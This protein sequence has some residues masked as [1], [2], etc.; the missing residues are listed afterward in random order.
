MRTLRNYLMMNETVQSRGTGRDA[1]SGPPLL[2]LL[3]DEPITTDST[4]LVL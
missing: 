1:Y 2:W 3:R 4:R